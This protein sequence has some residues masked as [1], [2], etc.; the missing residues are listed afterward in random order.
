Q[1]RRKAYQD[2]HRRVRSIDRPRR[3]CDFRQLGWSGRRGTRIRKKDEWCAQR[4]PANCELKE[5]SAHS[6]PLPETYINSCLLGKEP[7]RYSG[8]TPL[9]TISR[10]LT[11]NR[12]AFLPYRCFAYLAAKSATTCRSYNRELTCGRLSIRRF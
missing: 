3:H 10:E 12:L 7:T 2:S 8:A 1:R 5:P 4:R 6:G 11:R 9:T